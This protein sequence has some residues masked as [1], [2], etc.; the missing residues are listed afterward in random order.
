[1]GL[2]VIILAAGKGTRMVSSIPK[3]MHKL[4]GIAMLE[5]V[6]RTAES[7]NPKSIQVVYG[8]GGSAVR[9]DLDYLDVTWV[10]QKEQL[11]TGHAVMQALPNVDDADQVLVLYGDVPL[12]S[13]ETLNKLAAET[14]ANGLGLI[15]TEL[16]DPTGFG[17]IIRNEMGNIIS[18]V[19]HKDAN[20]QQLTVKEVNTGIVTTTAQHLKCWLPA[21]KNNNSQGE[22]YLTDIVSLAV[23]Q[24]LFVGGVLAACTE[25]VQGVNDRWQLANLEHYYQQAMAKKL[26]LQGVTVMDMNR[27]YVR[28]HIELEQDVLL[29]INVM[30]EGTVKIGSMTRIG[31]NVMLKDCDI[32]SN[33]TIG[34]H[35]IIDGAIIKEGCDV[36]PFARIRPGTVL[37]KGAKVGNFVELKKTHLGAGSKASHLSYLGD[38]KIGAGV[39]IG[40]GTIT[41][42]YDGVNK[43]V[44]TIEDGAFIGSN[45]SLVAPVTIG[46]NAT[47]GANSAITADAPAETLSVA[48][49]KQRAVEGWSRPVKAEE[50]A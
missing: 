22:Y 15:V 46:K 33:V 5:H 44:T 8:N 10:E 14:P 3:V 18:I 9:D 39:N 36:G 29:D 12:I 23:E 50:T 2:N 4:A 19:E 42:N 30:M 48:R 45:S 1:M 47:I 49:A 35:S 40:A 16:A 7:L 17:R 20:A 25:E 11:G 38:A 34:A 27:I 41:C 26:T 21:L 13:C 32:A 31:P 24:G 37:E 28:G 43:H 6:V